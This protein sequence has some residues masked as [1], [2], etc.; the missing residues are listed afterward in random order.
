MAISLYKR[1]WN[2]VSH[3]IISLVAGLGLYFGT[4]SV[5]SI[6]DSNDHDDAVAEYEQT[7]RVNEFW[8]EVA[9]ENPID[10]NEASD[11]L[12]KRL[13]LV[14]SDIDNADEINRETFSAPPKVYRGVSEKLG[15][16][17][18]VSEGCSECGD[19]TEFMVNSLRTLKVA[20]PEALQVETVVPVDDSGLAL[21]GL[22]FLVEL[23]LVWQLAGGVGLIWGLV[24]YSDPRMTWRRGDGQYDFPEYICWVGTPLGMF[25]FMQLWN[26]KHAA[27]QEKRHRELLQ[28][29]GQLPALEQIDSEIPATERKIKENGST[30]ELRQQLQRLRQAREVIMSRPYQYMDETQGDDQKRLVATTVTSVD[31]IIG[32]ADEA[33][34]A[35]QETMASMP[36]PT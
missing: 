11:Q 31:A 36:D 14:M 2:I 8:L 34:H 15:F 28:S 16:N 33:Y 18:F 32:S 21:T 23:I 12:A 17:P 13:S 3:V 9:G 5:N 27:V 24:K 25:L 7:A 22:P 20:G 35:F 6:G 26:K 10:G 19:L 30:E 29:M 4:V 1:H